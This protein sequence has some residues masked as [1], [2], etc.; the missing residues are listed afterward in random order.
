MTASKNPFFFRELPLEAPFCDRE[1]ELH[2]LT[3]YAE[4]KANIVLFSPRRFGKTSLVKHVQQKLAERGY[5]TLYADLFGVSSIDDVAARLAKA[6]FEITHKK[7]SIFQKAIRFIQAF[8][9]VLNPDPLGGVSLSVETTS[10]R[11]VGIELLEEMLVSLGTFAESVEGKLH[12]V[13]DEFQEIVEL[14]EA[15]SCEG[16]LRSH[17]QRHPFSYFFVGSRRRV[18]LSMF[19]EKKRPFFQS[20]I[21]YE[22]S[23]LPHDDLILFLEQMFQQGG[24]PCSQ[25]IAASIAQEVDHH[26]YYAQKLSFFLYELSEEKIA[27]GDLAKAMRRLI[28][29]ERPVFE[30][31]LQGLAPKQIALLEAIARDPTTSLFSLEYMKKHELG[32]TGGVQGAL[33]RLHLLD[34]VEQDDAKRWSVV[35]PIFC[36][37]LTDRSP[38]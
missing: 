14:K 7:E 37:W 10:Q 29:S 32:S 17:I 2:E 4:G 18:L 11:K 3:R 6:V 35:D 34:L 30:A 33:K 26:P 23:A 8:R 20:A 21:N 36:R 12:V 25:A 5:I 16:I 22:L 1:R 27:Q 13:L 31:L 38:K 19:N 28:E 9:P 24:K 15:R